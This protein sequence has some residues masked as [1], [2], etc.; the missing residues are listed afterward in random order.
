MSHSSK[1]WCRRAQ[2]LTSSFSP[3]RDDR[4]TGRC[5][6][7][8]DELALRAFLADDHQRAMGATSVDVLDADQPVVCRGTFTW[9]IF[10]ALPW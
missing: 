10:K 1:A 4:L 7:P 9:S 8:E 3:E 6:P 5:S 2:P